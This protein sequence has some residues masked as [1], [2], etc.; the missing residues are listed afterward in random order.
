ML[1]YELYMLLLIIFIKKNYDLT[2][3]EF[4]LGYLISR[5]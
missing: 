4:W 2:I 1:I 3:L 5:V